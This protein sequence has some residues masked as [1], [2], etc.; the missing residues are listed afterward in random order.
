MVSSQVCGIWRDN[1][2]NFIFPLINYFMTLLSDR[3]HGLK[4]GKTLK[5]FRGHTSYVNDAIFTSDGG[6]VITASSDGSV[7]VCTTI[8]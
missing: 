2:D 8:V 4:S 3:I 5:E 6:R 1:F 7:K